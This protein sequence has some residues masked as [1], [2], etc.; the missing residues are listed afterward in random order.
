M[1]GKY[2]PLGV[3]RSEVKPDVVMMLCTAGHVDHGKTSLVKLLTGC[4][5]DRLK[6][7]QERGLTIE[8]GFAPCY[9]GGNLCVGIVDVPGH[10]KF[11]KNMVAGVSGIDM[12]I[13]VIAADDGIM[14]Q[15]IEHLQ[16]M[17]LLG[18]TKGIIALT[19][20]DLVSKDRVEFLKNEINTFMVG[21]FL[22][23]AP[24]YPVSSETF[25]GYQEFYDA[26]VEFI[27]KLKVSR[28]KGIFRMPVEKIFNSQGF[29]RIITGIP[30]SGNVKTGDSL[31]LVPG[32][33]T[34]K[35][36]GIQCFLRDSEAGGCGQCLALNIP[37]FNKAEIERG[38]NLAEPNYLHQASV[39]HLQIKTVKGISPLLKNAE[40]IK[41]HAGT[42]E[43][44]GKIYLLEDKIAPENQ[45]TIA[46]VVISEPI[47]AAAGDRCIIRR[48][49]P[50]Q[51]IAGGEIIFINHENKRIPKPILINQMK[52]K[53]DF[54]SKVDKYSDEFI[55]KKTEYYLLYTDNSG[56]STDKICRDILFH[57]EDVKN[58]VSKLMEQNKIICFN[59][60]IYIHS[61][62]YEDIKNIIAENIKNIINE[63]KTLSIPISDFRKQFNLNPG[64]WDALEKE[65]ESKK[66]IKKSDNKYIFTTASS[67]Y[68]D[69]QKKILD[70]LYKIYETGGFN[71]PRPDEAAERVNIP[72]ENI[73]K[74]LEHLCN[75]GRLIRLNKN[76]LL[77][78]K[79]FIDAQNYAV[80][81]IKEKGSLDSAD[82][83]NII[84]STRKYALAILDFLD[85][86]GI[87]IRFENL[88]KL[89]KDFEKKLL[90]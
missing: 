53:I 62:V 2:K 15:T 8:L 38:F 58:A 16:I 82:F 52:T 23:N 27:N 32:N 21:T 33:I 69:K 83:K 1:A 41:F 44:N 60:E 40:I 26:L 57:P 81:I 68:E 36:K 88:R 39:F 59:N 72:Y 70:D 24:V 11:I 20:T 14:P 74:L 6:E 42:S 61:K 67:S 64:I 47:A 17:E 43:K 46:T 77:T 29:G 22:E 19:K 87:T 4:N 55:L 31:E 30:I 45:Q 18:V 25:E 56:S 90:K 79:N 9:L 75:D 5:T 78:R 51:T 73:D 50:A 65:L 12:T 3:L 35:I 54:F 63:K 80:N 34:G 28:Q 89:K 66:L 85:L 10:E 7:E 37:D 86:K 84:S 48:A 13:L 76:V 49:S 71:S